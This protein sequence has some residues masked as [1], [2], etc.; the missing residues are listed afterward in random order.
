MV[1]LG[2]AVVEGVAV[3]GVGGDASVRADTGVEWRETDL[4]SVLFFALLPCEPFFAGMLPGLQ[5]TR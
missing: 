2:A 4:L 5:H 3:R 1:V